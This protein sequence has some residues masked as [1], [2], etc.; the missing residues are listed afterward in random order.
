MREGDR[1]SKFFHQK[2]SSKRHM[3]H[4]SRLQDDASVWKENDQLNS[5]VTDYFQSLF[6]SSH[7]ETNMDFLTPLV[8]RVTPVM[9]VEL[10]KVFT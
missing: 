5:L 9:N 4:I 6:S 1:N 10:S 2:A 7:R 3:N 8:D